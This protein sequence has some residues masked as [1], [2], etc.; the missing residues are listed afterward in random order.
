M[1]WQY[2]RINRKYFLWDLKFR[3]LKKQ[4]SFEFI[5]AIPRAKFPQ[6]FQGK[7]KRWQDLWT[8]AFLAW[9]TNFHPDILE[10]ILRQFFHWQEFF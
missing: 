4:K 8:E 9:S 10:N 5:F 7:M 2:Y 6:V 1:M 3:I